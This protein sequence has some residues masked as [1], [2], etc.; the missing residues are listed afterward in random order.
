[1]NRLAILAIGAAA[2]IGAMCVIVA[3]GVAI[4]NFAESYE[5]GRN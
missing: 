2:I 5:I 1:M 3:L 4:E